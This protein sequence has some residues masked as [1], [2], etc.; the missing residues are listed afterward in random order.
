MRIVLLG[1]GRMGKQIEQ[2]AV[3]Q[4]T[5]VLARLDH[6]HQEDLNQF[7]NGQ[8]VAIEFT[9]PEAAFNNVKTCLEAGLPVVSGTTGWNDRLPE[10]RRLCLSMGGSMIHASNFSLGV[11]FLLALARMAGRFYQG[12]PALQAAMLEV[13][14]VHKKDAPSGTA[15]SI[16]EAFLSQQTRLSGYQLTTDGVEEDKLPIE[17]IREGEVVGDHALILHTDREEI[18]LSHRAHDRGI[19]A[20]G[21]LQAARFLVGKQGVFTMADV[22]GL[23]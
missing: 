14:H 16:A 21:A 2:V 3:A 17:A 4:G 20:E 10:A 9:Q 22:L 19:F 11:N 8:T 12:N 23:E 13:H 15:I 18:T 6:N 1:Y 5:E 7:A